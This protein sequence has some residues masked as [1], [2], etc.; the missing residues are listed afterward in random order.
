[1]NRTEDAEAPSSKLAHKNENPDQPSDDT[2]FVEQG[3]ENSDGD[4]QQD[5][6]KS[7]LDSNTRKVETARSSIQRGPMVSYRKL[8]SSS[9]AVEASKVPRGK[10]TADG[11]R[12]STKTYKVETPPRPGGTWTHKSRSPHHALPLQVRVSPSSK[13]GMYQTHDGSSHMASRRLPLVNKRPR[14]EAFSED[15]NYVAETQAFTAANRVVND[16]HRLYSRETTDNNEGHKYEAEDNDETSLREHI[17]YARETADGNEGRKDEVEDVDN[18]ETSFPEHA[19]Q[20]AGDVSL[21][22]RSPNTINA[23][24]QRSEKV[25]RV[26]TESLA[27][28]SRASPS[29]QRMPRKRSREESARTRAPGGVEIRRRSSRAAAETAKVALEF[30]HGSKNES[31]QMGQYLLPQHKQR[32]MKQSTTK[33]AAPTTSTHVVAEENRVGQSSAVNEAIAAETESSGPF[34]SILD[35]NGHGNLADIVVQA[36]EL[37]AES[38]VFFPWPWPTSNGKS[39]TNKNNSDVGLVAAALV[40]YAKDVIVPA[41]QAYRIDDDSDNKTVK[42]PPTPVILGTMVLLRELLMQNASSIFGEENMGKAANEEFVHLL[43][44]EEQEGT[45]PNPAVFMASTL[46]TSVVLSALDKTKL[47][48]LTSKFMRA[49]D[50]YDDGEEEFACHLGP[51]DGKKPAILPDGQRM[52]K[53]ERTSWQSSYK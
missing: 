26:T 25:A 8:P 21:E 31:S 37:V 2:I 38:I 23:T 16:H 33:K 30:V 48:S 46:A 20:Q 45:C 13:R 10:D 1:M 52:D 43:S 49:M 50:S 9:G 12:S 40:Q 34:T 39:G 4:N 15:S 32:L 24:H 53:R 28:D 51:L 41:M 22:R 17:L 11:P 6:R 3:A 47:D 5:S 19:Q 35:E 14:P 27:H 42:V 29:S 7:T 36:T 18:D 44:G